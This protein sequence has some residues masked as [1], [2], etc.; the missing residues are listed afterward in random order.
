MRTLQTKDVFAFTRMA[1]ETGI[2][3]K[4]KNL[5]L[6]V[7]NLSDITA[8]SFGYDLLFT[9]F[10]AAAEKKNEECVYE[11][12]SGPLEMSTGEIADSDPVELMEKLTQI[13][14][15]KKWKAFFT[16]AANLMK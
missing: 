16:S 13:A 1:K 3:D 12:L 11:F 5:V 6:S 10:D 7:N 8:E 15:V 9:I 2:S 14:D 4:I